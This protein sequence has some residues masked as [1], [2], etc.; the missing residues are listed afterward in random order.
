MGLCLRPSPNR[1]CSI[2]SLT[3]L[4]QQSSL[5]AAT[6]R[7]AWVFNSSEKK[8]RGLVEGQVAFYNGQVEALQNGA[9]VVARDPVQFKWDGTA[10]QRAGRGR[11]P[12]RN[13]KPREES[14]PLCHTLLAALKDPHID[15]VP[16]MLWSPPK[17]RPCTCPW[18]HWKPIPRSAKPPTPCE[19]QSKV[20]SL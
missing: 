15:L 3:P 6:N 2:P 12:K 9:E 7:D 10:E 4:F 11:A 5:G 16:L 13:H 17:G 14:V 18:Q 19:S 20:L 1:K 8:L